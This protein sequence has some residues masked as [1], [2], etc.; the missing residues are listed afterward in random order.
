MFGW[1]GENDIFDCSPSATGNVETGA[2]EA[3]S[4]RKVL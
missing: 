3:G 4:S 1:I 2:Q